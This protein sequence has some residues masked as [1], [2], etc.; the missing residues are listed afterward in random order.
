MKRSLPVVAARGLYFLFF[1]QAAG[2]LISSIYILDLMHT[3]LDA[4][5]LGVLVF[6]AAVL[7][8]PFGRRLPAWL[9]WLLVGVLIVSRGLLPYLATLGRLVASAASVASALLLFPWIM[10]ARARGDGNAGDGDAG[11]GDAGRLASAGLALAIGLSVLLRSVGLGLDWSLTAE[12][13]WT[14]WVLGALLAVSATRLEAGHAA[15]GPAR[16]RGVTLPVIGVFLV[17]TLAWFAFSAPSVIARW[18]QGSY[19]LAVGAVSVLS[20]GWVALVL[21]RPG[22]LERLPRAALAAGNALFLLTL[23][24]TILAHR[25]SF[26]ASPMA[27]AVVV[28]PPSL[29]QQIP[30]V[31]ML[32]SF[33][34]LF[35]DVR[36]FARRIAEAEPSPR[37]LAP[38]LLL[39]SL[40]MVVL[41]FIAIFTNVWGY[42]DPVSTPFRNRFWLPFGVAAAA[43]GLAA[44]MKP[45]SRRGSA[46]TAV[47]LRGPL[48]AGCAA[49]LAVMVGVSAAFAFLAERP[50]ASA[51]ASDDG[52]GSLRVM[53]YNIQAG[54]DGAA[55][56][57]YDRQLALITRVAP[58]VVAL[59]ESDTARLGL[60]NDDLVRWFAAKLGWH[61][62]YG[63]TT[64]TGTFGTAILS[65]YPL[66][67]TRVSFTYSDTDEIGTA[68]AEIEAGGRTLTIYNVHP[69]GQ[70]DAMMSFARS[71]VERTAGK[72]GVIALGDYNIRESDEAWPLLDAALTEAWASAYPSRVG[73]EGQ[74]MKRRIDHIFVSR[75]LA[76]RNPTY[77]L[78]PQSATDHPMHWA[79]V[80]WKE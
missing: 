10:T 24:A 19:L 64:V 41:V 60:N 27:A 66:R 23:V 58:D 73:P 63:P 56:R 46:E 25:V 22:V 33:P 79:E 47:G 77:V 6:F 69:D 78:P 54:N 68:E 32:L 18:T 28:G 59:Q 36:L 71:L 26:P 49:V 30:L 13:G 76:V 40:S 37:A 55:E 38:G 11:N 44:L 50:K 43:I 7:L 3:S 57:S 35:V 42:I 74:D 29:L 2:T 61:S 34:V 80:T 8:L 31:L 1:I 21:R 48:F 62:W 53:T 15:T 75:D 65:R 67:D 70:A 51:V 9:G 5:A 39:G 16:A 72:A 20:L 45:A 12:G 17:V 4:R 52:G 14:G